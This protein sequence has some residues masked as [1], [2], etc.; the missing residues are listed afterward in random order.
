MTDRIAVLQKQIGEWA[1]TKGW[2]EKLCEKKAEDMPARIAEDLNANGQCQWQDE[3]VG[4]NTNAILAKLALVHSEVSEALE[5]ARKGEY[6]G[7]TDDRGKPQGVVTELAD[8]VIRIL[9]LC[10]DLGLDLERAI[11]VKMA[12]NERRSYRHGGKL[13]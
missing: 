4:P 10:D 1:Q 13:A 12:Y 6:I 2:G 7:F 5:A 11:D 3:V 8:T 9:H